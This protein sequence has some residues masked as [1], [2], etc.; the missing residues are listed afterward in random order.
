MTEDYGSPLMVRSIWF[1]W[2]ISFILELL[3]ERVV[4]VYMARKP[5]RILR[6]L[7]AAVMYKRCLTV[8]TREIEKLMDQSFK[9]RLSPTDGKLLLEYTK[10]IADIRAMEELDGKDQSGKK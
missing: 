7:N 6:K 1:Q 4:K 9:E 5:S 10:F 3:P 2:L 8:L